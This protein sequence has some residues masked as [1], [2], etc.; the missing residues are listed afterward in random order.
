[1][2]G[3]HELFNTNVFEIDFKLLIERIDKDNVKII[4]LSFLLILGLRIEN[5]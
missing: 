4:Y 3:L 1:M 2:N 5:Q